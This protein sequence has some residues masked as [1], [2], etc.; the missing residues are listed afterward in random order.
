MKR[1]KPCNYI[2]FALLSVLAGSCISEFNAKLSSSEVNILV[3]EGNII[4]NSEVNFYLTKSIPLSDEEKKDSTDFSN[5][6]AK[7]VIIGDDGFRSDPAEHVGMGTYRI[8]IGDLNEHVSYGVEI[9][10]EGETYR[11]ALMKPLYTPEIDSISWKQSGKGADVSFHVSTHDTKNEGHSYF[12]WNYEEDWEF[13]STFRPHVFFDPETETFY[14]DHTYP[15]YYCWKKSSGSEILVGSTE[16]LTEN[17]IVNNKLYAY[18]SIDEKL[19]LL[20][21]VLV[22][23]RAITKDAYEYYLNKN[24]FNNEMGGLFTPQPF[25]LESNISC[26]TDPS[27]KVIGFVGVS[28][29]T[30]QTRIFVST[31]K[32]T[33][34]N[35]PKKCFYYTKSEMA[36][37]V[38][39]VPI[40]EYYFLGYEP[41]TFDDE[42]NMDNLG[43]LWSESRCVSCIKA[44]GSKNKPDFWPNDHK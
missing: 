36:D 10:Y 30:T 34:K 25:E 24:K 28:M 42:G 27:K 26:I 22:K 31:E 19:S 12:I 20:Y 41:L 32:I 17:R 43:F 14:E 35:A 16:A 11:S 8:N 4:A 37:I 1:N 9:E 2:V 15:Y 29:N 18:E 33:K 23:Q 21:S 3:V 5:V 13:T 7:L 6:E 44:G 38:G 40:K 39:D